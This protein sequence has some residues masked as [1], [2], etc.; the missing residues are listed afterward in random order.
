MIDETP[1]G[2][3]DEPTLEQL[4]ARASELDIAGRSSMNKPQ[5]HD[6]IAVAE[7][8]AP[9]E[10]VPPTDDDIVGHPP[11]IDRAQE[12]AAAREERMVTIGSPPTTPDAAP[13]DT[14]EEG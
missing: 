6:A 14:D 8:L 12:R 4:R 9:A 2:A 13:A 3:P 7:G 5:L 1:T 11:A 10:D